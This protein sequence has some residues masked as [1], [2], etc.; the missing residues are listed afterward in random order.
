[1]EEGEEKC[2]VFFFAANEIRIWASLLFVGLNFL[3][4][5]VLC[6]MV[7]NFKDMLVFNLAD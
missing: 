1:M 2:V 4:S 5:F 6:E 7:A 3:I